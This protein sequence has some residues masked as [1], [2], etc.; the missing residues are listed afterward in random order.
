MVYIRYRLSYS[1]GHFMACRER[2]PAGAGFFYINCADPRRSHRCN[3]LAPETMTW[4]SDALVV[5]RTILLSMNRSWIERQGDFWIE[6]PVNFLAA[7]IWFLHEYKGGVYCTLPHVIELSKLPYGALFEVLGSLD[8]ISGLIDPFVQAFSNGT[9]E[10]LDGQVA[11]AKIPLAKLSSPDLYFVLTRDDFKLD[12]NNPASPK[13]LCLGGD[14]RRME[15][16]GPVISLYID[17]INRLCNR[18]GQHPLALVAN[19]FATIRAASILPTMATGRSNDIVAVLAVQDLAQLRV[20]YSRDETEWVFGIAGNL[21]CGQVGGETAMRVAER[22]P[23]VLRER[24]SVSVNSA[25]VSVGRQRVWEPAVTA[26]TVAGMSSGGFVGVVADDVSA[27][28]GLKAFHAR[29]RKGF[30]DGVDF[31]ELPVVSF[32]EEGGLVEVFERVAAEVAGMVGEVRRGMMSR[33]VKRD[34]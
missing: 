11:A 27:A 22:F 15:A 5:S 12:I 13:I 32:I 18:A 17:R 6:S 26:A 34:C 25:D 19:E 3:V 33:M 4:L 2:Y 1:H 20:L 21:F 14:P 9:T 24:A 23:Q 8:S 16:I 31:G 10:M 7:L 29:V 28:V 30:S